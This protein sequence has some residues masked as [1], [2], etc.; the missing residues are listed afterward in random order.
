[1]QANREKMDQESDHPDMPDL[2]D[3]VRIVAW[4][5]ARDFW[6]AADIFIVPCMC[7]AEHIGHALA[8]RV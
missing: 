6:E 7:S 3:D 2:I 5:Y 4:N 1:M 8:H